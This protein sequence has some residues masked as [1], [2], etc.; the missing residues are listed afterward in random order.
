MHSAF[1]H[2]D[3]VAREKKKYINIFIGTEVCRQYY[4][5][6]LPKEILLSEVPVKEIHFI[7]LDLRKGLVEIKNGDSELR[8]YLDD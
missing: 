1:Y 7:L 8:H 3:Y 4:I 6:R 2:T 5:F